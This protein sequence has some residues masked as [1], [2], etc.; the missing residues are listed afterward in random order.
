MNLKQLLVMIVVLVQQGDNSLKVTISGVVAINPSVVRVDL[1]TFN[2]TIEDGTD[3]DYRWYQIAIGIEEF[4][5]RNE[6]GSIGILGDAFTQKL[7]EKI[8]AARNVSELASFLDAQNI[9]WE[10]N[11]TD[12]NLSQDTE[13]PKSVEGM[14]LA[15]AE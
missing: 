8:V 12:A 5:E 15:Q 6:D 13:T 7:S 2:G 1:Y 3:T 10:L 9:E 14:K 11:V 4:T